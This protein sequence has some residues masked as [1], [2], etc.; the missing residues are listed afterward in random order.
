MTASPSSAAPSTTPSTP[1]R[2][3]A[4]LAISAVLIVKN[5]EKHLERVLAA[6]GFCSDILVL[7]SG[8]TDRTIEI[9][10]AHGARVEHQD[11]LGYGPQKNRAVELAR[12][13]W[14]LVI[15][16]DE[17]LDAESAAAIAGLDL[18]DASRC[19]RVRRRTYVGAREV[20]WGQWSP[21][22]SLRLF[23]RT[24]SR[25][26]Q[27]SVHESVRPAGQVST[28]PGA[29]HHYSYAD[30]AEVFA[31]MDVYARAKADSYRARGRRCGP[32]LLLMRSGW[33]FLR[34]YVFK[35]GFL[36]G[37]AG[38]IVALSLAVDVALG[39]AIASEPTGAKGMDAPAGDAAGEGR[40]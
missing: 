31:R 11:F 6:L 14:V 40:A 4:K 18:T 20:R 38:V 35:L 13:D 1:D 26:N 16:D 9:A 39:L 5:G 3:T 34:S 19:W 29:I 8:S 32:L 27:A 17:V 24:M 22:H 25:F 10:R 33:G 21:D 7:D 37:N 36:D 12:H 28:L 15:D 30:Y 23:N 2:A